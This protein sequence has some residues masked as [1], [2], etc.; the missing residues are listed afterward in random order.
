[1]ANYII[2][3]GDQKEYGPVTGDDI[4]QWII[5]GRLNGESQAKAESDAEFRALSAFPEFADAFAPQIPSLRMAGSIPPPIAPSSAPAGNWQER[6]YSLDIGGCISRGWNLFKENLGVLLCSFLIYMGI[7]VGVSVLSNI[8]CAGALLSLAN[9]VIIGPLMGGL[10]YVYIQTIRGQSAVAGDVFSGFRKNFLQLF[11]GYLVPAL[12]AG[13]CLLPFI[14]VFAVKLVQAGLGK[15]HATPEEE[16]QIIT[17]V[18]TS[19]LVWGLLLICLIPVIYL[20][21]S[22]AFTLPLIVDKGL[23]FSEAMKASRKMVGKHWWQV[24]GLT[25]IIGLINCVGIILCCV[26]LLFTMPIGFAA[27][28][29]AYETIFSESQAG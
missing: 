8:P 2:I 21:T 7:E 20:K 25:V 23:N 15:S 10:F 17:T 29:Y 3:G 26:G 13:L 5:E 1:M 27:L 18:M 16:A 28:M 11:L 12:F 24:F 14:I 9:L 4:R 22:W 19:P 6:D